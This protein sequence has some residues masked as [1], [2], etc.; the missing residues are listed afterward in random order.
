MSARPLVGV[1]AHPALVDDTGNPL[2]HYVAAAPY[3]K[4]VQRA[5]AIAVILPIV[6]ADDLDDLLQPVDAVVITGGGDIDPGAYGAAP[7][8]ETD[9]VVPE[10]DAA[11]LA[12]ARH[13]VEHDVPTLAI[14][15]G[16]Q[17]VNVAL[18]GTL[19]QHLADHMRVDLYNTA[20]HH[21]R[22]APATRLA[23]IV[24]GD[25][26]GVNTLHHQHLAE[27]GDGVRVVARAEDDTIEAIEIDGAPNVLGVQWHPEMLRH[28]DAHLALFRALWGA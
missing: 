16:I 24:G 3:V 26:L 21:V 14:C 13:L 27:T 22:V 20:A 10:R 7:H 9:N 25:T 6:D 18:G 1:T 4:A 28:L 12:L 2:R 17:V 19:H 5:G 15:R 23:G 11:D 8:P